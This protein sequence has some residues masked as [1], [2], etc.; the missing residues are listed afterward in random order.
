MSRAANARQFESPG[1][2][3]LAC[4]P[5][6]RE[7]KLDTRAG[8]VWP[9]L[10]VPSYLEY[11]LHLSAHD[12]GHGNAPESGER[13]GSSSRPGIWQRWHNWPLYLRI[14][15]AVALGVVVGLLLRRGPSSYKFPAG[16]CSACWV[17]SPR[18]WCCWPSC[19]R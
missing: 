3:F 19:R 5:Q 15:G 17:R 12:A 6:G 18:R 14:V 4:Q 8:T 11:T 16:S 2:R 1:I 10:A 9:P 13:G 7:V